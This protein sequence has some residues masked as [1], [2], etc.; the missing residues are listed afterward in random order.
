MIKRYRQCQTI[1]DSSRS[2]LGL[3]LVIQSGRPRDCSAAPISEPLCVPSNEEQRGE[4]RNNIMIIGIVVAMVNNHT[5][6]FLL[7]LQPCSSKGS[8]YCTIRKL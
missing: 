7:I 4:I 8:F 6:V 5:G 3:E 1:A 2:N